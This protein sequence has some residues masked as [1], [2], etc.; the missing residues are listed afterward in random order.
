MKNFKVRTLTHV[1]PEN[2]EKL[3]FTE[4]FPKTEEKPKMG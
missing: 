1:Q 4:T 3:H 2:F